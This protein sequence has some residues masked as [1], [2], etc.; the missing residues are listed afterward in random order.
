MFGVEMVES[1]EGRTPAPELAERIYYACLAAGL[2]FKIS[3]GAVLTLS[4]P[5][6]ITRDDLERALNI[7]TVAIAEA[8][9]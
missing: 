8:A 9:A 2:S 5:L 6:T 4:P 3:A 1:R 7:V